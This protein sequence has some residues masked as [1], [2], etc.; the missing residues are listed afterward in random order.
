VADLLSRVGA[1]VAIEF[2][3]KDDVRVEQ[4]LRHREDVFPG[5]TRAGFEEAAGTRFVIERREAIGDS[6]RILYLLRR[7]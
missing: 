4:L 3:P 7:R 6:G 2:V 5:Y 1:W